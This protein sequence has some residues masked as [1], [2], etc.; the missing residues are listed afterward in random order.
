MLAAEVELAEGLLVVGAL[1]QGGLVAL[2]GACT[3]GCEG[4][5]GG[6]GAHA[7]GQRI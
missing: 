7:G 3:G 4:D 5:R 2:Q 6:G 1:E